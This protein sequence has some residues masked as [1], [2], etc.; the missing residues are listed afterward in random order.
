MSDKKALRAVCQFCGETV[1][2]AGKD[3]DEVLAAI[4]RANW[5][6]EPT[7]DGKNMRFTC[8][9]VLCREKRSARDL[10]DAGRAALDAPPNSRRI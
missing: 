6:D 2:F 7:P 1:W 9:A 4:E 10:T 8:S 5:Q 3:V